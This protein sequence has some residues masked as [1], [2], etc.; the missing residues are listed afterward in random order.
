MNCEGTLRIISRSSRYGFPNLKK[1][2][3]PA[4]REGDPPGIDFRLLRKTSPARKW[5]FL[6]GQGLV[7]IDVVDT[8]PGIQ[9]EHLPRVFDPFFTTKEAGHGTGLGLSVSQRI[10]ESFYGDIEIT[11]GPGARTRV[12]IRLPAL[13]EEDNALR[14]QRE[15][16]LKDGTTAAHRG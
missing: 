2:A 12:R 5:P 11:S 3:G 1:T 7:E 15:E 10:I 16:M 9:A 14:P 8:G 13:E 4:R 6:E